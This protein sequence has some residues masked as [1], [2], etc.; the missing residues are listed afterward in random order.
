MNDPR[1]EIA[2]KYADN[3]N[4]LITKANSIAENTNNLTNTAKG[5]LSNINELLT[6]SIQN[7]KN[8]AIET[9]HSGKEV[10]NELKNATI[11]SNIPT[12][13]PAKNGGK[14]SLKR[15]HK[16]NKA[17]KKRKTTKRIKKHT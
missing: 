9:I 12:T 3:A 8:I 6:G 16:K 2:N 5:T 4:T 10:T 1:F 13:E 14:K 15:K 7:A 11:G 17:I